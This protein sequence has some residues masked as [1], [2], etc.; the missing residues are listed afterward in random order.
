[1]VR[2]LSLVEFLHE[3]GALEDFVLNRLN[4]PLYMD[5]CTR[6]VDWI[7]CAFDWKSAEPSYDFWHELSE[8]WHEAVRKSDELGWYQSAGVPLFYDEMEEWPDDELGI[9]LRC[10]ALVARIPVRGR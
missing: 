9:R 3:H 8:K 2:E 5:T 4:W 10:K 6:P 7:A 1:M